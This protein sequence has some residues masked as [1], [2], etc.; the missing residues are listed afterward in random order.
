MIKKE[1]KMNYLSID[2][3]TTGCKCQLFSENGEILKYLFK[4]YGFKESDGFYYVDIESIETNLRKMIFD[5]SS[6]FEITSV[7]VSSLGE[8][9]VL[10]DKDD[11]VLFYPMLYTDSRGENEAEIIKKVIGEENAFLITGVIPHSMYSLSKLLWIFKNKPDIYE[12]ADKVMLI[13][14]YIGYLMTG[15]RVIDYALASRTGAF[16]IEK[17][18]FSKE[19]LSAF[20]INPK[21]F[22]NP[23]PA[24]SIVGKIKESWNTDAVLVLGSHDQVCTSLGAGVLQEGDAADGMGTVECITTLFKEKPDDAEMGRQGYP[25]VPYPANGLYCTYILNYSCCSTV[26]WFRKNLMHEYSGNEKDF[27]A[28]IEKEMKDEPTGI[29]TLPYFSGASTP[30]QDLNAKGVIIGLTTKTHDCDLY[31]SMFEGNCV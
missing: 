17:K 4:E 25:C 21:L 16:D 18:Q 8:S 11:N 24:G 15:E 2:V 27:F 14:D 12:K 30:Y 1:G 5:I 13:G 7:C 29:L 31:K 6:Q 28:Y 10:L 20:G 9:F 26:N 23:K 19:I 22:S 3:G